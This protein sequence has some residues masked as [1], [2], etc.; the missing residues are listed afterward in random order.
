MAPR[1]RARGHRER[2]LLLALLV[3]ALGPMDEAVVI[4]EAPIISCERRQ[5]LALR[6]FARSVV[7]AAVLRQ[8]NVGVLMRLRGGGG[9]GFWFS[10]DGAGPTK[11]VSGPPDGPW[12]T[13]SHLEERRKPDGSLK[14]DNELMADWYPAGYHPW[15]VSGCVGVC[16]SVSRKRARSCSFQPPCQSSFHPPSTYPHTVCPHSVLFRVHQSMHGRVFPVIQ[17][18]QDGLVLVFAIEH[19]GS[20]I[21]SESPRNRARDLSRRM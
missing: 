11:L 9:P 3:I 10:Q 4:P 15:Y 17:K 8:C 2:R 5:G 13:N 21:W 6:P 18:C 7:G 12:T 19:A 14:S 16:A 20:A 1:A